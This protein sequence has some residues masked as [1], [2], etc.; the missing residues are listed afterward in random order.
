M[1]ACPVWSTCWSA[2]VSAWPALGGA[3]IGAVKRAR[4]RWL[5][6]G[7]SRDTEAGAGVRRPG[8]GPAGRRPGPLLGTVPKWTAYVLTCWAP[9]S[10]TTC[11]SP[12]SP[13]GT[14]SRPRWRCAAPTCRPARS[15]TRVTGTAVTATM[16]PGNRARVGAVVRGGSRRRS[17][18]PHR[19][20]RRTDGV[21]AVLR[22]G[23]RPPGR[24]GD[25]D[26]PHPPVPRPPRRPRPASP[27]TPKACGSTGTPP[28]TAGCTTAAPSSATEPP[29]A[30]TRNTAPP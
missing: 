14:C 2:S 5:K 3:M 24:G 1:S 9:T 20:P 18:A 12:L 27:P 19:S 23:S 16:R 21:G 4:D 26:R 28:S 8:R 25:A 30:S 13:T 29:V 22:P 6:P 15:R 17:R 10:A 7:R 11:T